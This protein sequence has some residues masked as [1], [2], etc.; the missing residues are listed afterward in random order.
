MTQNTQSGTASNN[1]AGGG[2]VR[3]EIRKDGVVCCASYLPLCGYSPQT[4]K[5]MQ[6]AGFELYAGGKKVRR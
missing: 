6:A 5:E 1:P 3:Y 2:A 4:I